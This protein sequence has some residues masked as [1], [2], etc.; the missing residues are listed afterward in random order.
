MERL[1]N[2]S[3][4][5]SQ[6]AECASSAYYQTQQKIAA[7]LDMYRNFFTVLVWHGTPAWADVRGLLSRMTQPEGGKQ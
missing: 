2:A 3:S 4:A 1:T 6:S 7:N 5:N